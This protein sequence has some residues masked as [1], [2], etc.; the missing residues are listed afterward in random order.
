MGEFELSMD[1]TAG[2]TF[3]DVNLLNNRESITT[4]LFLGL[5]Q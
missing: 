3:L 2:G 5:V 4:D 1:L